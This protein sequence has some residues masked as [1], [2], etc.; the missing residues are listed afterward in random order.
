MENGLGL[1][2]VVCLFTSLPLLGLK[3][4]VVYPA[5][6]PLTYIP[7][8]LTRA[9]Q[10]FLSLF[11]QYLQTL[12]ETLSATSGVMTEAATSALRVLQQRIEDERWSLIFDR[13]LKNCEGDQVRMFW[14]IILTQSAPKACSNTHVP[15]STSAAFRCIGGIH[16]CR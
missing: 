5:L 1:V 2:F 13:C 9:K 16:P 3:D 6:L 8:L 4:Q 15:S 10:L 12:A 11:Q 7:A 14:R